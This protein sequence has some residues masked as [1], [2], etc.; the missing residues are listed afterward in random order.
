MKV[1]LG[2]PRALSHESVIG[3][4]YWSKVGSRGVELRDP[5]RGASRLYPCRRPATNRARCADVCSLMFL[6]WVVGI[7]E[8]NIRYRIWMNMIEFGLRNQCH[9]C[10]CLS[11]AKA[12]HVENL[13]ADSKSH[14]NCL[15]VFW[16][17]LVRTIPSLESHQRNGYLVLLSAFSVGRFDANFE[18][19]PQAQSGR[20]RLDREE[21][22]D[23]NRILSVNSRCIQP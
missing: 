1:G 4:G 3:T 19:W 8:Y 6:V 7:I 11:R 2:W 13:F 10:W 17:S 23:C 14:S 12:W 15:T 9:S 20:Q 18:L 16:Q 21:T 22:N 5:S